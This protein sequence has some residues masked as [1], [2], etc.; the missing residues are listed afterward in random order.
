MA[1]RALLIFRWSAR[2]TGL[3]LVCM[4]VIFAIGEGL[5]KLFPQ[6]PSVVTE[7]I[8]MFLMLVGFLA[9]WRWEVAGGFLAISGFAIFSVTEMIA[10]GKPPHGALLLFVVPGVLYLATYIAAKLCYFA[11]NPR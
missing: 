5:P 4:V 7:F 6:P 8:A 11:P 1:T 3:L 9:G 10:S 2:I